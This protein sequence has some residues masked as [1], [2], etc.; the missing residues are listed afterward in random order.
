MRPWTDR[1]FFL[2]LQYLGHG[3]A[4]RSDGGDG[5]G[6]CGGAHAR[7]GARAGRFRLVG[8]RLAGGVGVG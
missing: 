7:R 1:Q 3:S 4:G 2:C 5:L 6:G 8:L